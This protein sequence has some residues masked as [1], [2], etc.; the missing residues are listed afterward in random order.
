MFLQCQEFV[1]EPIMNYKKSTISCAISSASDL[2]H[3]A[4]RIT[5]MGNHLL[6]NSALAQARN[7]RSGGVWPLL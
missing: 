3:D 2:A 4:K 6:A 1:L 7:V 5:I